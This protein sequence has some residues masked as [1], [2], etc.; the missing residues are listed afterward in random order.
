MSDDENDR[1]CIGDVAEVVREPVA[2]PLVV[3]G[4]EVR[5]LR[6]QESP[7]VDELCADDG[8]LARLPSRGRRLHA[9]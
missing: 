6:V 5:V 7:V 4:A 2:R 8:V 3:D 9:E 1:A